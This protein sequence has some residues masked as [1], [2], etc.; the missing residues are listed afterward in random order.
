[1]KRIGIFPIYLNTI[2]PPV[3]P[4]LIDQTLA[5]E[6]KM[7]FEQHCATCHGTYGI[8]GT[9]PNLL[10]K[11]DRIGTDPTL[12]NAYQSKLSELS[13]LSEL[14]NHFISWFNNGWFGQEPHR[15][16]LFTEPGYVAQPLDGI[17]ASAPYLH[18]GSI[19]TLED[20][21]NS[22]QRPVYWERSF[23]PMIMTFKK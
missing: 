19:P 13:E 18:N 9:Y 8:G 17:W 7:I 10:V 14:Q 3:Y 15:T 11:P 12:S 23:D 6:G 4:E 2:Q 21:L 1:M 5:I 16:Q 22:N 20:L